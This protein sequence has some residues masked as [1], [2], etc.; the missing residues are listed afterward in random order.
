MLAREWTQ[1]VPLVT[2]LQPGPPAFT[3]AK[4]LDSVIREVYEKDTE[5]NLEVFEF[6][7]GSSGPTPIFER[8]INQ[9]RLD[10]HEPPIQFTM[11]DLYPNREAWDRLRGT[12]QWL[13]LEDNPVNAIS[14]PPKAMSRGSA[15]NKQS[16]EQ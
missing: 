1:K 2:F 15:I 5:R 6:C 9:H 10:N 16:R 3:A 11:S 4:G 12:S 14:P 7:A 13:S 8:L